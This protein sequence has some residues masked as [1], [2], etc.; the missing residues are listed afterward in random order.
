VKPIKKDTR[1]A[2]LEAAAPLIY[3]QGFHRTGLKEILEAAGVPKGSFYFYFKS[4]EDFGL[5]VIDHYSNRLNERAN[6]EREASAQPPLVRL[7]GLFVARRDLRASDGCE[8]GCPLGNLAQEMSDLSPVM[9]ERLRNALTLVAS[10]IVALLREAR[11]RGELAERLDPVQL[12]EFILD[13][14]EGALLRMK[15][16]KSPE[17]LDRFI[18]FIFDTILV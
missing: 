1:Q 4:K 15:A 8:G 12:G 17:P 10:H 5:A 7:R 11:D 14:W 6:W 18:H 2:I 13:A 16:E 9:R 3:R